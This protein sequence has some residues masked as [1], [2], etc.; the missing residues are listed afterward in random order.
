MSDSFETEWRK[1]TR[2]AEG[3]CVEVKFLDGGRRVALRDSKDQ[4]GSVLVFS[5]ADW[6]AFLDRLKAGNAI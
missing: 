5:A 1:S 6:Q 4:Y 2:S 3:N